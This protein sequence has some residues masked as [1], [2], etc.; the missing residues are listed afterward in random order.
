M[1]E[2][3]RSLHVQLRTGDATIL[4]TCRLRWIGYA[5]CADRC[6]FTTALVISRYGQCASGRWYVS[7]IPWR[8]IM[9]IS[10]CSAKASFLVDWAADPSLRGLVLAISLRTGVL[11]SHGV[12]LRPVLAYGSAFLACSRTRNT[13]MHP[14]RRSASSVT[15]RGVSMHGAMLPT[16]ARTLAPP[17]RCARQSARARR[18]SPV[19]RYSRSSLLA[20]PLQSLASLASPL[21][22]PSESEVLTD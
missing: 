9:V 11:R 10:R 18:L 16:P 21:S 2:A 17:Y 20:P 5:R 4:Y 13:R 3:R 22:T 8:R 7:L 14:W 19:A 1:P 12:G 6:Y 15:L